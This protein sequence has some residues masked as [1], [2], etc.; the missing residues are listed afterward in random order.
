MKDKIRIA[1]RVYA[2]DWCEHSHFTVEVDMARIVQIMRMAALVKEHGL[3]SVTMFDC[4]CN[5]W[6][7]MPETKSHFDIITDPDI[8][9][10]KRNPKPSTDPLT[11]DSLN[12]DIMELVIT[13][14]TFKWTWQPKHCDTPCL[15]SSDQIDIDKA[16][17]AFAPKKG[18]VKA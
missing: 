13:E 9:W 14:D 8:D 16:W 7:A 3:Y 11:R 17:A 10:P 12:C 18:K 15:C 4:A 5:A 2:P 1:G 6:D